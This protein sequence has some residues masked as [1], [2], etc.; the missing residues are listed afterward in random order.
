M[1]RSEIRR[2]FKDADKAL[3]DIAIVGMAGRFPAARNLEAFWQNLVNGVESISHLSDEEAMAAGVSP[4]ILGRPDYVNAEFAMDD[5]DLFDAS[6]FDLPPKEAEIMDPQHRFFLE[7]AWEALENAGYDPETYKGMIGVYAGAGTSGYLLNNLYPHLNPLESHLVKGSEGDHLATRVSYKLNLKGPSMTVQTAC[8]TSLVATCLACQSLLGY[9]CDVALAGGVR[10][11]IPHKTGYLSFV[12]GAISPDGHCR[13]FDAGAEGTA[14]GAGVGVVVLRRLMDALVDGDHIYAVIK[15]S[16]I[17]NDGSRKVGYAAPSVKGQAEVIVMAYALAGIEAETIS[18]VE[19]HGTGTSMGDPIEMAA[20]IQAFRASTQKKHFCAI[21]SVKT[22]IGHADAAAGVASVIKTALALEHKVIPPSLNFERPNPEI[23]FDNSPFY[24]N[25]V[26]SEWKAGDTPRRAG[27]SAFGIGGTNTHVVLEEAPPVEPSG[28][29]RPW[30]V[31]MLSAKTDTALETASANLVEHLKRYPDISLADMAYTLQVGRRAFKHRRMVVC[32]EV[33]EAVTALEACSRG[34]VF[35]GLAA[36]R[37]RSVVF[38]FPGIGSLYV[39]MGAEIYQAEPVFSEQVDLCSAILRA[40]LGLDL[41]DVL[42]PPAGLEQ[43]AAG[44]MERGPVAL[45]SLFVT[46]YALAKLWASWGIHPQAMIGHSLGEYVAACVAGVLSLKDA[47]RLV[48]L[49]GQ[50]FDQLPAGAMTT[51]LLTEEDVQLFLDDDLSLA[52]VNAPSRCVVS[53]PPEAI[54]ALEERLAQR[55]VEFHRM[56]ASRAAHSKMVEPIL[57]PFA[58]MVEQVSLHAPRIPYVSNVTGTWIT[59]EEATDPAHWVNHLRQTVRFWDGIQE[60]LGEPSHALVEIGP[61]RTLSALVKLHLGSVAQ[62]LVLSSMRLP[63]EPQSDVKVLLDTLG[64]LWLAGIPVDWAGFY[65]QE[66]RH[67]VPLPT[68]P[69]ER[70]RYWVE[71]P[72]KQAHS[73]GAEEPEPTMEG[74]Y[75]SAWERSA[76]PV[77]RRKRVW[78]QRRNW[79]LFVDGLGLG[80][81]IARR[82][83]REGQE[84][85]VVKAGDQFEKI[86]DRTYTVHPC[87]PGDYRALLDDL[88][89]LDRSPQRMLHL[90]S[91]TADGPGLLGRGSYEQGRYADLYSL[92]SLARSIGGREMA[93]GFTIWVVSN[94]VHEVTGQ[95]VL[96]PEKAIILGSYVAMAREYPGLACRHIDLVM[97]PSG[98][99]RKE[100]LAEQIVAEIGGETS[101]LIVAYR[102]RHRWTPVWESVRSP[103]G[104]AGEAR[105]R[106]DGTYLVTG[107]LEGLGYQ[108]AE[109]LAQIGHPK[110]VFVDRL[111]LSGPWGEK[112]LVSC[113]EQVDGVSKRCVDLGELG[114]HLDHLEAS[115]EE[116]VALEPFPR[117]L[118]ETATRLSCIYLCDYLET[119]GIR[120]AKGEVYSRDRMRERLGILPKFDKLYDYL[121]WMLVEEGIVELDGREITFLKDKEEIGDA[122]ALGRALD[123]RYPGFR[124]E[125][126]YLEYCVGHYAQALSG[127]VEAISVLYPDGT[128]DPVRPIMKNRSRFSNVAVCLSLAGEIVRDMAQSRGSRLRILEVGGGSGKLTQRVVPGLRDQDVEYHFTDIGKSFVVHAEQDALHQGHDFMTF[129][130]LDISKDPAEQGYEKYSFDVILAFDV[131]QATKDL[132]GTMEHLNTLLKPNGILLIV[133]AVW[134]PRWS[135]LIFGLAEGFWYFA[136]DEARKHL[137]LPGLNPEQW[138]DVFWRQGFEQVSIYPRATDKRATADR[139]LIAAQRPS[140]IHTDDYQA[141]IRELGRKQEQRTRDRARRVAALEELGAEVLVAQADMASEQQARAVVAHTCERFG[142]VNGVIHVV[143][144]VDDGAAHLLASNGRAGFERHWWPKVHE[145]FALDQALRGQQLDLALLVHSSATLSREAGLAAGSAASLFMDAYA[146]KRAGEND[147]CWMSVNWDVDSGEDKQAFLHLLSLDGVPQ[148]VV[149]SRRLQAWID[150]WAECAPDSPGVGKAHGSLTHVRPSLRNPYVAPRNQMERIVAEIWAEVFGIAQIGIHDNFFELGGESLM[151]TRIISRLREAFDVELS[152]RDFLEAPMI[153][154]VAKAV[155]EAKSNRKPTIVPVSREA[156]RARRSPDGAIEVPKQHALEPRSIRSGRD[157][158][159]PDQETL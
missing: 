19:T 137:L 46:S 91:V 146:T 115:I 2:S 66:H 5:I 22:N 104:E 25:T 44:Q 7:C 58:E 62:R 55:G 16:A 29:S 149:S 158:I 77:S 78:E 69:F 86:D 96:S 105:L 39:G 56:S 109:H 159:S 34:Q 63:R 151:A 135:P 13:A 37:Q 133:E 14:S 106:E 26:L 35:T 89:A 153:S 47:L 83:R 68:Y 124:E 41:R 114:E 101:D 40:D 132:M 9:Q 139:I 92:S 93:P 143:E 103:A 28:A 88:Q 85:T 18:Y 138:E 11:K 125:F 57:E 10:I 145:L 129:G 15:G 1:G 108:F 122:S 136:Q 32:R 126:D 64:R 154:E 121:V 128:F 144:P 20:L 27:V 112:Q 65:G 33:E 59:T 30:Q 150:R 52:V 131:I 127:Q 43:E 82:L 36:S 4:R 157:A 155:E 120:A 75:L 12:K 31:V 60:V 84:V 123:T 45:A 71:P 148:I 140:D 6:F 8:S 72:Q 50:L 74:I 113:L 49:R 21:G 147:G 48:V 70:Q 107:G 119:G 152:V 51:V 110:L 90:W 118:E 23:D 53:G 80:S 102:G 24:V 61:G 156:Y 79:L 42:Y 134:V 95:E 111:G 98:D 117:A 97:P 116:T 17:N 81:R 100:R 87:R 73:F 99:G 94:D 76:L 38:M 141:W 67:R 3:T 130:L 54:S 142:D